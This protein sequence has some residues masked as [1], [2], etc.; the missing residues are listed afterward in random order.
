MV[1]WLVK[2]K[3][4]L[5]VKAST[6]VLTISIHQPNASINDNIH[7]Y[8]P[9]KNILNTHCITIVPN[10]ITLM[11]WGENKSYMSVCVIP[12]QKSYKWWSFT[13][14]IY[15]HLQTFKTMQSDASSNLGHVKICWSFYYCCQYCWVGFFS[16]LYIHAM[17]KKSS[18]T[19]I[20]RA[21]IVTLHGEGYT[22]RD[23]AAKLDGSKTWVHNAI[24]KFNANGIFHDRKRSGH[25]QKT[26]P[27]EDRSMRQIVMCSPKSSSRKSVLFY[28]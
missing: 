16:R 23:I 6:R 11:G 26:T 22:E 20:W 1:L 5:P 3:Y 15:S 13:F 17:G 14:D 2:P 21:E 18:L 9:I 4:S 25:P 7:Q 28:T 8:S 19:E 27:M 12:L 24:V 10:I